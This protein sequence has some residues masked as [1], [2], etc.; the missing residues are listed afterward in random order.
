[1]F[2]L[3]GL[4]AG[5]TAVLP[6]LRVLRLAHTQVTGNGLEQYLD[7]FPA[8]EELN[9]AE[10][11][12]SE[13][14][15]RLHIAPRA[16]RAQ[17]NLDE[18]LP[19]AVD[20]T[21]GTCGQHLWRN[22]RH[23]AVAPPTQAHIDEG[24]YSAGVSAQSTRPCSPSTSDLS[25]CAE[26]YTSVPPLAEAVAP[27]TGGDA[28][29]LN[30]AR[31]CHGASLSSSAAK[32][33]NPRPEFGRASLFR[34][35]VQPLSGGCG[36]R[37]RAASRLALCHRGGQWRGA[38]ARRPHRAA[39]GGHHARGVS[40]A[41]ALCALRLLRAAGGGGFAGSRRHLHVPFLPAS[42]AAG[43]PRAP[44]LAQV[45]VASVVRVWD[46]ASDVYVMLLWNRAGR[47]QLVAAGIF[48]MAISVSVSGALGFSELQRERRAVAS[49]VYLALLP[50]N[51]QTLVFAAFVLA[52]R[53]RAVSGAGN[54]GL[55][56]VTEVAYNNFVF[57]SGW[58]AC[59]ESLPFSVLTGTDVLTQTGASDVGT[60]V[61]WSSLS[62]S[63]LSICFSIACLGCDVHKWRC[64]PARA[65]SLARPHGTT[66]GCLPAHARASPTSLP[67]S[68]QHAVEVFFLLLLD[69]GWLITALAWTLRAFGSTLGGLAIGVAF[70]SYT[71]CFWPFFMW[72]H[73]PRT[74]PLASIQQLME[75][76]RRFMCLPKDVAADM[77]AGKPSVAWVHPA[78]AVVSSLVSSPAMAVFDTSLIAPAPQAG[79]V[80]EGYA[81]GLLAL[82]RRGA[83]LALTVAHLVASPSRLRLGVSIGIA[84]AH[85]YF[86]LRV[87][88]RLARWSVQA[89]LTRALRVLL[90]AVSFC[91]R[92]RANAT[93]NN[94]EPLSPEEELARARAQLKTEPPPRADG[95]H[96][97]GEEAELIAK[98]QDILAAEAAVASASAARQ[99]FV[100]AVQQALEWANTAALQRCTKLKVVIDVLRAHDHSM[101]AD[102]MARCIHALALLQE[103]R[104]HELE[105]VEA[106]LAEESLKAPP[107]RA[108]SFCAL[109]NSAVWHRNFD[110]HAALKLA[111]PVGAGGSVD[112][113]VSHA[114]ADDCTAKAALL[115][116]FI[117]LQPFAAETMA[118][119]LLLA[120]ACVPGGFIVT[121]LNARVPWWALSVATAG[122]GALVLCWAVGCHAAGAVGHAAVPWRGVAQTFWLDHL[123][124]DQRTDAAKH[125]GILH[126]GD[127]LQRSRAMLVL[128]SPAYLERLWC[129]Y[130]LAEYCRLMEQEAASA[131]GA[132]EA[133]PKELLMLSLTWGTWWYPWNLMRAASS[134][135]LSPAET[136]LLDGYRCGAARAYK[137]S[138]RD[139]VLRKI[140]AHWSDDAELSNGEEVFDAYVRTR[141]K[142]TLLQ[143][144]RDYYRQARAALWHAVVMLFAGS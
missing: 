128:F 32:L 82:A 93:V 94:A 43:P 14:F 66:V 119:T 86:S 85:T 77:H 7:R 113:F 67:R 88:G 29:S 90:S 132:N 58:N 53:R 101:D 92:G 9:L 34:S 80:H 122:C 26:W 107:L 71:L 46:V 143:R 111:P 127:S 120:L 135:E 40:R 84:V 45:I 112:F 28:R 60:L 61:K 56:G 13:E 64:A 109:A 5:P 79:W 36:H 33:A 83:L 124:I 91:F 121:A 123:C 73:N 12:L 22:L 98:C 102:G 42:G 95:F 130:E 8:L 18:P 16:L 131:A 11:P 129:T 2:R 63:V 117:F 137:R 41:V 89:G 134:V 17:L 133:Q 30:C 76:F 48:F 51:V 104:L 100:H 142:A 114:R 24:A 62:L 136:A 72:L 96:L 75:P 47:A 141:V 35:A 65:R 15:V 116:T 103:S 57:Y 108:V 49:W 27:L 118:C 69:V 10:A 21:C 126:L 59:A 55:G 37:P 3:A 99:H 68:G 54:E 87:R 105:A 81:E 20:V 19:R 31:N 38:S 50:L 6:R 70:G 138:D 106:A 23:F 97:S 74:R 78:N 1:M 44:M 115:R 39:T 4:A 140:R 125:Q 110:P 25:S 52:G 144:K 139:L